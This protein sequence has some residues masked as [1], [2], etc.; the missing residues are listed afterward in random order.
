METLSDV[1]S[2]VRKRGLQLKGD[3]ETYGVLIRSNHVIQDSLLK[4][5]FV[6][7]ELLFVVLAEYTG[8]KPNNINTIESPPDQFPPS[9]L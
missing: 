9:D 1:I 4:Q 7:G 2:T 3:P 6:I 8:C 5:A